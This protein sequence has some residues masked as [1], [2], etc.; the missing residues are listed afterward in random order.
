MHEHH[1]H[2]RAQNSRFTVKYGPNFTKQVG[3]FFSVLGQQGKILK[4]LVV[5][6]PPGKTR[7]NNPG[8]PGPGPL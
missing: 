7:V 2:G 5:V 8:P 6:P 1:N 3:H 4:V